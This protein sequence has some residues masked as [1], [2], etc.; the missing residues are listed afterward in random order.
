MNLVFM[1]YNNYY[2][3]IIKKFDTIAEYDAFIGSGGNIQEF[4]DIQ[5]NPS[6]GVS[7]EQIVNWG[8]NTWTPDYL[9]VYDDTAQADVA[10]LVV[11]AGTGEFKTGFSKEGS[12]CL[13]Y[14]Y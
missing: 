10:I 14:G 2:N 12:S 4:Y 9:V 13:Y 6:D 8:N 7:T 5:F 3:R 1:T 11:P